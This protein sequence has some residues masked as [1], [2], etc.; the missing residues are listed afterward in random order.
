MLEVIK[1]GKNSIFVLILLNLSPYLSPFEQYYPKSEPSQD[2]LIIS[3]T[4]DDRMLALAKI[5][6]LAIFPIFAM[7]IR[8]IK[9]HWWGRLSTAYIFQ[10]RLLSH[11]LVFN[12]LFA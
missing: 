2:S 8:Y 7:V 6:F 1:N 10:T 3:L 9:M 5:T 4:K 12:L 11:V